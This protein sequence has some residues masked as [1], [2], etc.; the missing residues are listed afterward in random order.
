MLIVSGLLQ[1][2]TETA[3]LYILRAFDQYQAEQGYIVALTS[4]AFSIVLLI[5]IEFFKRGARNEPAVMTPTNRAGR[6]LMA[7]GVHNVTK[8]FGTSP[9]STTSRSP[10]TALSPPCS[11]RAGPAS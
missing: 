1:G 3:T 8:R 5:G 7:I 2:R 10:P 6:D 11:G 4:A 9:R